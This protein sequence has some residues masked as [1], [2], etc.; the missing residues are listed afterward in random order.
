MELIAASMTTNAPALVPAHHGA[1]ARAYLA[2]ELSSSEERERT[3]RRLMSK[4]LLQKTFI[5]YLIV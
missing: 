4:T 3:A 2:A 5:S 1:G